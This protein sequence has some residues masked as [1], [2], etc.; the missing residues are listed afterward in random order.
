VRRLANGLPIV[1]SP[2]TLRPRFNVVATGAESTTVD[3][4]PSSV[5][6]RQSSLF[7]AAWT[8]GSLKYL[9]ESGV[10][11]AT[12]YETT[13]WRGIMETERES[14]LPTHFHSLPGTLFPVYH[15]FA[16]LSAFAG[17]KVLPLR[18]SSPLHCVG[19]ALRKN[20]QTRVL[21]ANLSAEAQR[22]HLVGLQSALTVAVLDDT[23]VEHAMYAPDI[24]HAIG[25][26]RRT[27]H[28]TLNLT[29]RPFAL[30]VIDQPT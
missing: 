10:V 18:S 22:L 29:L 27:Y 9:S 1:I 2:V 5:D 14:P 28:S 11:S 13:R 17:G 26:Q 20:D 6:P 12:Y 4:L 30:V 3:T 23:N 8:L 19:F 15:V 16:A 7:T 21:L 24:W 25:E